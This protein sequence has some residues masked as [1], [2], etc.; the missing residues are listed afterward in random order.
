MHLSRTKGIMGTL[1]FTKHMEIASSAET[2]TIPV[3][4]YSYSNRSDGQS[5]GSQLDIKETEKNGRTKF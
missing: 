3:L 2:Q 4:R 5:Q 1:G